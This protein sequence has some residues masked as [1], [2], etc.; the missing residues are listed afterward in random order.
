M[1][2]FES[3]KSRFEKLTGWAQ[4]T[5]GEIKTRI[6]KSNGPANLEGAAAND[7]VLAYV[8]QQGL[9]AIGTVLGPQVRSGSGIFIDDNGNQLPD[10]YHLNVQWEVV[11]LEGPSVRRMWRISS[12]TACRFVPYSQSYIEGVWRCDWSRSFV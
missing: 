10:E 9:R 3:A 8:N 4:P 11:P 6:K 7:R 2:A 5:R 12:A 1:Y